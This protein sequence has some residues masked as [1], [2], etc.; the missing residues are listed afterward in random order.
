MHFNILFN[1]YVCCC[2][3]NFKL[4][5]LIYFESLRLNFDENEILDLMV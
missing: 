1:L 4:V 3:G 2:W 5:T